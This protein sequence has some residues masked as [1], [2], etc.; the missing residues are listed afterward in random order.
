VAQFGNRAITESE[1][2]LAYELAPRQLTNQPDWEA[3]QAVLNLMLNRI[4]L[5]REAEKQGLGDDPVLQRAVAIYER[6]AINRELYLKHIRD[7]ITVEESEE[8][9]AFERSKTTLY[10]KHFESAS[11]AVA[12]E[13]SSN[14]QAIE[15]IPIYPESRTMKS[16]Q[17]GQVDLVSWNDVYVDIE[18]ILFSLPLKQLS[19]PYFDGK[20]YHVF[21]VIDLEKEVFLRE[22]EFQAARESIHSVLRKRK[23]LKASVE[24]VQTIMQPQELIIKAE[25]LNQLTECLWKSRPASSDP[26]LQFIANDEIQLI[27]DDTGL[28]TQVL[29]N[30]KEGVMTIS[31]ILMWYKVNPQKISYQSQLALRESIKK[32]VAV[33][34]RNWVLSEQGFREKLNL[35]PA[36]KEEVQTQREYLLA[37]KM[38]N[39]LQCDQASTSED[40]TFSQI[41]FSAYVNNH[42]QQLKT[43]ATFQIFKDQ[44]MAVQTTD[45]GLTRK[46]DFTAVHSQ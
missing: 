38:L 32:T 4:L 31:D 30:Y 42:I 27:T 29:A 15:H 1:F 28:A 19:Q 8:R 39:K 40:S 36:V 13:I 23:E 14:Q 7:R 11:K 16:D 6:L 5:A 3:R 9:N 20:K 25:A 41:A 22:N 2:V 18:D 10:I 37:E 17:F 45:A 44:L 43:Q 46:I 21:Q 26:Q 12:K 35:K 34:V 24:F 33:V